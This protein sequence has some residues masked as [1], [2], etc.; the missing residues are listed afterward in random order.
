MVF[1]KTTQA[2]QPAPT[3][4]CAGLDNSEELLAEVD[5]PPDLVKTNLFGSPQKMT[6]QYT[7]APPYPFSRRESLLTRQLHS[8][9][10]HSDDDHIRHPP[11]ALSTQSNWS[12]HSAGSTAELTSDDGISMQSPTISPPLPPTHTRN[13]LPMLE[14]LLARKVAIAGQE[15]DASGRKEV[16]PEKAVEATLGRKRCIM[17]ACRGKE[18]SKPVAPLPLPTSIPEKPAE[19]ELPKRKCTIKFACP[20]RSD[21]QTKTAETTKLQRSKSPPPMQRHAST[22]HQPKAHRG[23][24]STVTLGS[25]KSVRKSPSITTTAPAPT[26]A[27]ASKSILT[28]TASNVAEDTGTEATRFHEFYSSEDEPEDWVQEV[29]CH[30]SRLTVSDTLQKENVLRKACEEVEDEAVEDEDEDEEDEAAEIADEADAFDEE[31]EEDEE[32]E[33]EDESEGSDAGFHSDDEEGFAASDS[34]GE[35]SDYEWWRPG[36]STAATSIEHLGL[37]A[38]HQKLKSS[39]VASSFGSVSSE[40]PPKSRPH[41]SPRNRRRTPAI[42]IG[43]RPEE[44]DLPDSTDFVCGTL[45][46][47]RPL[48]Q[49]YL[50]RK[51]QLEAAKHKARPQDIDP[52]FP[53]SDP[54]MDEEDDEDIEDPEESEN[55]DLVHGEME[56][57]DHDHEGTLRRRPSP[58][59]RRKINTHHSPPPARFHSPPPSKRV[60]SKHHSPPPPLRR[61]LTRSPPPNKLFGQSPRRARSPA[62]GNM[63]TS[64]PNTLRS[65]PSRGAAFATAAQGLAERPQLTHTASLPRG[66]FLI[67]RMCSKRFDDHHGS[68]SANHPDVPKRHAIDIVKGLEKKRQRRKEK[69]WQKMCAKNAAK[70]E[71]A[72]KVKP[73]KGAERMREVGL[74][75]QK[76][77]G[78]AEHIISV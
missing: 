73:G 1:W 20:T 21:S 39:P 44:P 8:E 4:A 11:R 76:Y 10:E 6:P 28:R 31:D 24:D 63:M 26:S 13:A 7:K 70:G 52:T 33:D 41:R 18:E 35:E 42:H 19:I 57:L 22:T 43:V 34:D 48:E 9:T 53:T 68:V 45:D 74:Q 58:P 69:M 72:Y 71:K 14:K 59:P 36:G 38:P 30:R 51:K 17:F 60:T 37:T 27:E 3:A 47:D 50:N 56:E 64:P 61:R 15:H 23:S 5:E 40:H 78:K 46:E 2:A 32:A 77:K 29:T 16:E 25:P 67:S 62:P 75:L 54:D 66:G 55:E 49:A 65:S 12:S